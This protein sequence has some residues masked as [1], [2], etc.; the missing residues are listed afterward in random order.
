MLKDESEG[1]CLVESARDEAYFKVALE[2]LAEGGATSLTI[3]N[4]CDA[5]DLTKGSFYHHFESG[6]DFLHKFLLYWEAEYAPVAVDDARLIDDPVERLN[7]LKPLVVGLHH[8]AESAIRALARTDDFAAEVQSRV[9]DER[10]RV[11]EDTLTDLGIGAEQASDLAH[12]AVAILIGAQ[13]M[14]RPVDRVQLAR[15]MDGFDAWLTWVAARV[16]SAS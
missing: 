13:H 1:R 3:A 7:L 16:A 12:T 4:L 8:E 5:L 10:V 14:K 6:S 11:V 9:D 2:L 15:Q